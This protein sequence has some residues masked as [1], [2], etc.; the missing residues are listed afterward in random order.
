ML[1]TTQPRQRHLDFLPGHT[2][3]PLR[4]WFLVTETEQE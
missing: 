4:A 1:S 2:P 3:W